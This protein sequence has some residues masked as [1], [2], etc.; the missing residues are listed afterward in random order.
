ME[1][2]VEDCFIHK[3][4]NKTGQ[5]VWLKMVHVSLSTHLSTPYPMACL[6]YLVVPF[7]FSCTVLSTK[8]TQVAQ[9]ERVGRHVTAPHN[10][11]HLIYQFFFFFF[12]ANLPIIF[13]RTNMYLFRRGHDKFQ[14]SLIKLPKWI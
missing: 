13:K 14:I 7:L 6:F 10:S 8:L 1:E 9:V 11:F 5:P 3:E 12:C 2:E 4:K